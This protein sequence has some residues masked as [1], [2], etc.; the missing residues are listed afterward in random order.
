[1]AS[2]SV[3]QGGTV[4]EFPDNFK[5]AG[6]SRIMGN[7]PENHVVKVCDVSWI[8]SARYPQILICRGRFPPMKEERHTFAPP[9]AQL[10]MYDFAD[11]GEESPPP[12][13]PPRVSFTYDEVFWRRVLREAFLTISE[14]SDPSP[15]RLIIEATN[16][17]LK[18][19]SKEKA[20]SKDPE[21]SVY[22]AI[23]ETFGKDLSVKKL[24]SRI[25]DVMNAS[26]KQLRDRSSFEW[27][28][29]NKAEV[30]IFF[31]EKGWKRVRP[32]GLSVE[33]KK[34]FL[35]FDDRPNIDIWRICF[36]KTL[37]CVLI[38]SL[39]L[40]DPHSERLSDPA[41]FSAQ[42]GVFI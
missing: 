27:A 22:D 11:D 19:N 17:F 8:T 18:M 26:R 37:I 6:L 35:E 36:I 20:S 24:R 2:R 29:L 33:G 38:V 7:F 12:T 5:R 32:S 15:Q 25:A 3:G 34:V 9:I 4:L 21:R 13:S 16:E 30:Y 41:G 42:I 28:E 10:G 31:D 39:V 40:H 23:R 1:M 14:G